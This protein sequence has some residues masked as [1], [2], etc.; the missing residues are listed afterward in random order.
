MYVF[1]VAFNP[2]SDRPRL[3]LLLSKTGRRA[4]QNKDGDA[5]RFHGG[6]GFVNALSFRPIFSLNLGLVE[7]WRSI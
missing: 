7:G 3:V 5:G 4:G 2:Q 6:A 1:S